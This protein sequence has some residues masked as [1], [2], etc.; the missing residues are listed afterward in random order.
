MPIGARAPQT[1]EELRT[2]GCKLARVTGEV[3][4]TKQVLEALRDGVVV[5]LRVRLRLGGPEPSQQVVAARMR[6][7]E[8]D[9]PRALQVGHRRDAP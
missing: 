4:V 5:R 1:A 6:A 8:E 2:P 3:R 7:Q 9:E